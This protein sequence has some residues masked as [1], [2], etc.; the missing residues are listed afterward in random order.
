MRLWHAVKKALGLQR[1]SE[2][3]RRGRV[4][5]AAAK[6][7]L[8]RVGLKFLT[9]NF[10]TKSSEIDLVF[11]DGDCLVFVEMKARSEGGWTRPAAVV[12]QRKRGLL[13]QAA[14]EYLRRLSTRRPSFVSTS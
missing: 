13:S 5:E 6:R 9:A 10:R 3:L 4:G 2:H 14:K 1:D 11:R 12:D 7:H 8:K